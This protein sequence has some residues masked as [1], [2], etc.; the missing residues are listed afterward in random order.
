[1]T[2]DELLAEL[3]REVATTRRHLSRVPPDRLRWRPHP[4][5]SDLGQLGGHLVDCLRWTE[6]IFTRD[7]TV[8]DPASYRPTPTDS[9]ETLL[10]A[11]DEAGK[12]S[13]AALAEAGP[14]GLGGRWK[15]TMGG[16]VLVDRSKATA[17][18]DMTV[19]HLIHH[20]GQLSVYLRLLEVPVPG[21]YGPSADDAP[22]ARG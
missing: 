12:A 4:R 8:F 10:T 11:L 7:E 1:M 2:F 20:R 3:D 18:R 9:V 16:R 15:L 19:S 5:S 14:A 17:H 13:R 6:E 22:P 21:S